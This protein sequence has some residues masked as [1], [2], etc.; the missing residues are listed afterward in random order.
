ACAT[1]RIRKIQRRHKGRLPNR[2]DTKLGHAFSGFNGVRFLAKID[3]SNLDLAAVITV[4][5]P[6]AIGQGQPVL[7]SQPAA[8]IQQRHAAGIGQLNRKAGGNHR[9]LAGGKG[10]RCVQHSTQIGCG[11][12]WGCVNGRFGARVKNAVTYGFLFHQRA[13][14]SDSSTL[15]ASASAA[16]GASAFRGRASET[17][18]AAAITRPSSSTMAR[19]KMAYIWHSQ[20][21][22][23][24]ATATSSTPVTR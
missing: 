9:A 6:H 16:M 1:H 20:R 12:T 24:T 11:C 3:K 18:P 10:Q 23:F 19:S 17:K 5:H 15:V 14:P 7:N 13:S 4:N 8:C 2:C 22:G 21:G